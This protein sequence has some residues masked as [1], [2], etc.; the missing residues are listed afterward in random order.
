MLAC[1]ITNFHPSSLF[2]ALFLSSLN[3]W[4]YN[5]R[6]TSEKVGLI[7]ASSFLAITFYCQSCLK[8]FCLNF[9]F[10][11]CF[12]QP[13]KQT[14][15]VFLR[16]TYWWFKDYWKLTSKYDD[17]NSSD[18]VDRNSSCLSCIINAVLKCFKDP[19]SMLS[20]K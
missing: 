6:I 8:L 4:Q 19:Y 7:H 18:V 9:S 15:E 5:T 2:Y 17:E 10:Q 16:E 1:L 12:P 20:Y 14:T 11:G 13:E 3:H